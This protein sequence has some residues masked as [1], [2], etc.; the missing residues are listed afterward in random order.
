MS[1]ET[2]SARKSR[3]SFLEQVMKTIQLGSDLIDN[4]LAVDRRRVQQSIE[5]C[6]V[7]EFPYSAYRVD[8]D[9]VQFP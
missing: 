5:N 7:R 8:G 6:I 4:G 3:V 1:G 2:D 9:L